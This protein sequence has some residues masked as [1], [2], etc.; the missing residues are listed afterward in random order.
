MSK[1]CVLGIDI[2]TSGVRIVASDRSGVLLAMSKAPIAAPLQNTG[3]ELQDPGIWWNA[4][5]QAFALLDLKDL[6]VLALAVDG[7]SGT[8]LAVDK[9]GAPLGLASMYNDLAERADVDKVLA[10]APMETAA[11]GGSSPLARALSMQKGATRILHQAD[12]LAGQ[13]SGR[14]DMSDENN[15][16]KSGYDPI[17]RIWPSWIA[18][19]GDGVPLDRTQSSGLCH[20]PENVPRR[21]G[22]L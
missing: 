12:W 3:R 18:D 16:L 11:R 14:Y 22:D 10:V 9:S 4:I 2:G 7:T 6:N 13:F 19:T 21:L 5:E 20:P 8:I 1:D 15:A 17:A